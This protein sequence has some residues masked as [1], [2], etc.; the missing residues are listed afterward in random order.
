MLHACQHS[1]IRTETPSF[2]RLKSLSF[3]GHL[4]KKMKYIFG[5]QVYATFFGSIST[6]CFPAGDE[7]QLCRGNWSKTGPQPMGPYRYLLSPTTYFQTKLHSTGP[8]ARIHKDG[9]EMEM[10]KMNS[11]DRFPPYTNNHC[12]GSGARQRAPEADRF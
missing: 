9:F 11:A 12:V 2:W 1:V 5:N 3:E 7:A 4:E 8:Y 10:E 6:I